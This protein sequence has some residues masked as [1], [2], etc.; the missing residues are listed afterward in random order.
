MA[1]DSQKE[2][3]NVFIGNIP[4]QLSEE[5][6]VDIA[7]S[8]G[9]VVSFRLVSDPETG[10]PRGYGFCEYTDK[11][12]A[13]S[14]IRNLDGYQVMGRE[15]RVA[16]SHQGPKDDGDASRNNNQQPQLQHQQ[17]LNGQPQPSNTGLP[18]LPPGVD[19]PP[20]INCPD[21]ISKTINLLPTEQL[22]DI[23]SQMKSLATNDPAKATELLRQAPQ[24]SFAIFQA[25]LLM[26]LVDPAVLASVVEQ[27]AQPPQPQPQPQPQAPPP[28]AAPLPNNM[29]PSR[30]PPP[31]GY[32]QPP[33]PPPPQQQYAQY[34][35]PGHVPTP[36]V[37][38]QPY[39]PPPIQQ[40]PPPPQ[41]PPAP[42]GIDREAV[43]KQVLAMPQ[44]EIDALPQQARDQVMQ[45][46]NQLAAQ[47]RYS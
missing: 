29:P 47:G 15:L 35:L 43:L 14:A 28:Q 26:G 46:K 45:L 38:S 22:L 44:H 9:Q 2:G 37:H 33:P 20:G 19:L 12:A 6:V 39:Q 17:Q 16:Y 27:A 23:L 40:Q 10:R 31:Q 8:C 3:K 42:Q 5:A 41:Q 25:M 36:P 7:S 32:H 18:T 30:G 24:L 11:D 1:T 34:G 13:A 4:Y 21:A